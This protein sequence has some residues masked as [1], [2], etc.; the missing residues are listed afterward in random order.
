MWRYLSGRV[1]GGGRWSE[2]VAVWLDGGFGRYGE[3][4]RVFREMVEVALVESA[5]FWV[6]GS[7]GGVC[8]WGQ[9]VAVICEV[10]S[11]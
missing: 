8:G 9:G 2:G 6:S 11:V 1:W 4:R 5:R 7:A 10:V 3:A